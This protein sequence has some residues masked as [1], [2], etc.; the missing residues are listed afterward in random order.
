MGSSNRTAMSQSQSHRPAFDPP[1]PLRGGEFEP[2]RWIG[3]YKL[4]K[5][6]LALIAGLMVLRLLHRDLPE[7]ATKWLSRLDID[8]SSRFGAFVLKKVIALHARNL[9]WAAAALF[10]YTVVA[11]VE[12]IGLLMR[13]AWAEWLT[14][15][16][17]ATMIP[18]EIWECARRFT[19]VRLAIVLMNVA[20]VV[21]L[22]WRIR[23]DQKKRA[24][25]RAA[26]AHLQPPATEQE[27]R[28][29]QAEESHR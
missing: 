18:L 21:Y 28:G 15:V 10:A 6:L 7:V 26:L 2:L 27:R 13:R 20:V 25:R 19:S 24:A 16:T 5:A 3:S 4:L 9:S 23:R 12:G 1:V 22:I 29:Q 17:T 11:A 8:P 14:V